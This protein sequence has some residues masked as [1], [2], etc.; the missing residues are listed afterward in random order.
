LHLHVVD[1][2]DAALREQYEV[3]R[4]VLAEIGAADHPRLLIFNKCDL[5]D[6]AERAALAG[7][8]PEAILMAASLPDDIRLLHG[9]IRGFFERTMEEEEFVIPYGEQGRVAVL[10]ERCRVLEER[11]E[12]D[13]A[14]VRVLAPA[15]MLGGLRREWAVPGTRTG[16]EGS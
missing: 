10:H 15:S 5:L 11:Y 16:P 7:E 13:G 3:T 8:F 2:A 12:E 6:A 4:E 9:H 1:A 14:H